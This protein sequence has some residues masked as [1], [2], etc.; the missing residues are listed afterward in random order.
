VAAA[1]DEE[2]LTPPAAPECVVLVGLPG[3]GKTTF[4]RTRFAATH[5]H[6]SKD[7]FPNVR[8]RARRQHELIART[9]AAGRSVVVDNTNPSRADRAPI[10]AQARAHG[11]RV[12]AC[13]LVSTPRDALA[14]NQQREGRA[15]VPPV[16]IFACAKRLQ[17]PAT[18][19]GFDAVIRVAARAG[20]EFEVQP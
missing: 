1:R 9:L 16:A 7:A 3:A 12:V 20:G 4:Y 13:Y 15:R 18:D 5:E 6:V 2:E 19:E 8:D 14:R 10:I 11:A 17:E